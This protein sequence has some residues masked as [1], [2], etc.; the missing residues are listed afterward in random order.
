M[1]IP[2]PN[3]IDHKILHKDKLDVTP[4][5]LRR[6]TPTKLFEYVMAANGIYVRAAR[7]E[8]KVQIP[9]APSEYPIRGLQGASLVV[10][11]PSLVSYGSLRYILTEFR[12]SLPDEKLFYLK[13]DIVWSILT[14]PQECSPGHCAPLD[15]YNPDS[16]DAVIEIH[17]HG[18]GRAFFSET[19]DRDETGFKV[20]AVVGK[21]DQDFPEILVRVGVY[22]HMCLI[23]AN[24][25]FHPFDL[26]GVID[27]F[28]RI[29]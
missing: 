13:H 5:D 23:P 9:V 20:Y 27:V 8:L 4:Y 2:M 17:S 6:P 28:D 3:L 18:A 26:Y 29:S 14:P 11:L 10:N 15:P 22:G 16:Q 25:V 21:L 19:D 24:L 12:L 1:T 7:K